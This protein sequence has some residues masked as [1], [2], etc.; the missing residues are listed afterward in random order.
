MYEVFEHGEDK[1]GS[2]KGSL[3]GGNPPLIANF[4]LMEKF[5]IQLLHCQANY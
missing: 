2:M 4:H 5:S 1:T 3:A